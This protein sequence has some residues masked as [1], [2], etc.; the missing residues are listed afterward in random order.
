MIDAGVDTIF[1]K[2]GCRWVQGAMVLANVVRL[3]TLYKLDANLVFLERYLFPSTQHSLRPLFQKF[4]IHLHLGKL[5]LFHY[6]TAFIK[7]WQRS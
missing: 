4:L 6:I 1:S 3:G 5:G 7:F 2:G